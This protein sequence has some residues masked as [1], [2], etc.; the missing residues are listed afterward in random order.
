MWSI[1][2]DDMDHIANDM[3]AIE[4]YLMYFQQNI[5]PHPNWVEVR[6]V[7][8]TSIWFWSSYNRLCSHDNIID[9]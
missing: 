9:L 2:I 4:I 8:V 5:F 6:S 3:D 7:P 1:M